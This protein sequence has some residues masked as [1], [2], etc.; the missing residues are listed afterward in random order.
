MNTSTTQVGTNVILIAAALVIVIAGIKSS[1]SIVIPFLLSGFIAVLS[2][3]L[4]NW[5]TRRHIPQWLALLMI[6][7][8][9][10]LLG[11]LLTTFVGSTIT[12]F[13]QDMPLY[14]SKLQTLGTQ[15]TEK[16][17]G[18]GIEVSNDALKD[19]INPGAAMGMVAN[20]FNGL[21]NVLTNTFLILFTV[22]FMLL[23][24]SSFPRK[25]RTAFGE[26]TQTLEHF[27]RFSQLVQKYL[28]IKT[29]V[30]VMTG[31]SIGIAL[32]IIGVDYAI[33]WAL[34]AF[35]LN[36]IPTIGSIIAAIPAVLVALIQLGIGEA[37]VTATVFVVANTIFGNIVEPK[38]MGRSLGLS[39]LIVF[40][41]LVFW[42]W[43]L[44]S[45]GMLLSI[46]LT[47]VVKIA[48]ETRQQT[49]W[50]ATLLD[51]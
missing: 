42:G 22:A 15:L 25:L 43:V 32:M 37:M 10:I 39:T 20:V 6:I 16:L 46:P 49:R 51:E 19:L 36:Y 29:L 1:A 45:V 41:S 5:L 11:V 50:V 12:A 18:F 23:E 31:V 8:S 7:S 24:T 4:M 13:Y 30:S 3:P 35:M 21:G 44:G 38:L 28:V 27:G 9:F 2:T 47:M 48:F 34:V 26:N 40:L 17:Q 14:E 33:M